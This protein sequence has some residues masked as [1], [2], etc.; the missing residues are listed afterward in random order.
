MLT[1]KN[2]LLHQL[3]EVPST[4]DNEAFIKQTVFPEHLIFA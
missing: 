1:N 2:L 4:F 3:F